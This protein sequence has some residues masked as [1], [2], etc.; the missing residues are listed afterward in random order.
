MYTIFKCL[1]QRIYA[2]V[3][4]CQWHFKNYGSY[5]RRIYTIPKRSNV[6]ACH[7]L[8]SLDQ[9]YFPKPEK[10]RPERWMRHEPEYNKSQSYTYTSLLSMVIGHA[11][12]IEQRIVEMQ[13]DNLDFESYRV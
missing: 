5:Y 13:H 8:L 1:C 9:K 7:A 3:P 6:T 12:C 10:Y 11:S 2:T 4:H